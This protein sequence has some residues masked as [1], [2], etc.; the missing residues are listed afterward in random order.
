MNYESHPV[1]VARK[2]AWRARHWLSKEDYRGKNREYS[3]IFRQTHKRIGQY[4]IVLTES[5]LE[6]PLQIKSN[7]IAVISDCHIPFIDKFFLEQFRQDSADRSINDLAIVGDFWDCDSLSIYPTYL[8]EKW[9]FDQEKIEIQKVL[10]ILLDQF[11]N[12]Y[13]CQGN[14]EYRWARLH[15]ALNTDQL[16]AQVFTVKNEADFTLLDWPRNLHVTKNDYMLLNET[17][18]LTHPRNYRQVALSV[19][20]VLAQKYHK[21]IANAHGHFAY[22]PE[23]D[24]VSK[25]YWIMDLGGLFNPEAIEYMQ[26]S[27]TYPA[28]SRGY[29]FIQDDIPE[30][31]KEKR[32]Q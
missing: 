27:S 15:T 6:R 7:N 32:S 16:W 19:A 3:R 17:W 24:Q 28:L 26:R 30:L 31:V 25:S 20:N 4:Q 22:G 11:K 21:N 14:H 9:S 5:H 2:N 1:R 23:L 13:I 8:G 18:R 29:G 10:R 12:V